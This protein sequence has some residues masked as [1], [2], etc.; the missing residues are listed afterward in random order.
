MGIEFD[1]FDAFFFKFF[2]CLFLF[3]YLNWEFM[4]YGLWIV[5]F[6]KFFKSNDGVGL[7][8]LCFYQQVLQQFTTVD[9]H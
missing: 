5:D 2:Y 4:S 6:N 3:I 9:T 8:G 1:M 7:R